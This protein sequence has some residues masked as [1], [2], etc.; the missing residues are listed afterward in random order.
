MTRYSPRTGLPTEYQVGPFDSR[1]YYVQW[2]GTMPGGDE[3]SCGL[4]VAP[5]NPATA[6]NDPLLLNGYSA[7]VE[8]WH[9]NGLTSP[10]AKLTFTKVNLVGTDGRYVDAV[11]HEHVHANV[12]GNGVDG[13]TPSNQV[14][15]AVSLVTGVSRGPAHRG[16]FYMPLPTLT[17][18]TDGRFVAAEV[19]ACNDA[20]TAFLTALNAVSSN[21]DV[22][23]YSRKDGR[24]AHRLVTGMETGRVPDTQRRRRNKLVENYQ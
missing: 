15:L 22:A 20:A 16:R 9:Q 23:I 8:A 21:H 10:R 1:H 4:R 5:I 12:A 2:G 14:A 6:A 19:D 3:W 13:R 24:A 7:A 18:G 11:T 17:L